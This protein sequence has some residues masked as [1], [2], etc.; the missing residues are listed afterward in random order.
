MFG[1]RLSIPVSSIGIV[2]GCELEELI[3]DVYERARR[4]HAHTV[5][6]PVRIPLEPVEVLNEPERM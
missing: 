4:E 5:A 6:M 2:G 3:G 1:S